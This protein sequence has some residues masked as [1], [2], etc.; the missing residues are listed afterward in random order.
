MSEP[1]VQT[2]AVAVRIGHWVMAFAILVM[3]GSG[4]R[5][6]N[7]EPILP[8]RFPD[9]ATLGGDVEAALARHGDPGV[10][11]ALAWHFAGMWLLLASY[12]L[13]ILWGVF[14]GHFR[15]DFLPVGPRSFLRDFLAAARFRLPHR[16]GEY[17]AV[18]RAF[19]WA[20][21]TA[22]AVMIVSGIAIWKPVQT[23]PLEL[24]FGGFQGA[25]IVHFV[26]MCGI[27]LFLC[28]H[29]ALVALVPSTLRA[30]VF[31]RSGHAVAATRMVEKTQ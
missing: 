30:M 20:V 9:W 26:A 12:L 11:T 10:A 2:H 5:I 18:Q 4:W 13:L 7:A 14:S 28:V 21:L 8:F 22:I 19:Y 6:Y 15:R 16:L 17:N 24:L 25:R 31:G 1:G 29:L 27:V 23:Y 3:I